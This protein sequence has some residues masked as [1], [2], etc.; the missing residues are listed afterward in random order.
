MSDSQFA[1]HPLSDLGAS[2]TVKR[3]DGFS[4]PFYHCRVC[5][6]LGDEAVI[7]DAVAGTQFEPGDRVTVQ[8]TLR[9]R[10]IGFSTTILHRSERLRPHYYLTFP[11]EFEDLELR[12]TSRLPALIPVRIVLGEGHS[13]ELPA[14]VA[15]QGILINVSQDGCAISTRTSLPEQKPLQIVLN[16]P[17]EPGEYRLDVTIVNRK[18]SDPVFVHGARFLRQSPEASFR[19]IDDWMNRTRELLV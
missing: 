1:S 15:W 5:G 9:G 19:A 18:T 6:V 17:G 13:I 3:D 4:G 14:E 7:L 10:S 16:L 12:K 8:A 2:A 11:I